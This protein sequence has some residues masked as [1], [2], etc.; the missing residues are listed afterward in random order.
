LWILFSSHQYFG[1][2]AISILSGVLLFF[3]GCISWSDVEKRIPWGIV[4]LYGGAITLGIGMH[5]TGAGTW[6]ADILFNTVSN[7]LYIVVL[8][9]IVFTVLLTGIMS[10]VGAVAILLPIGI[11]VAD[12]IG[13]SPLL[14]SMIIALCGGLAFMLVISTPGNAITYSSG[15]FSTRDL[16]KV[17]FIANIICIIIVFCVAIFY[18]IEVLHLD[19][20]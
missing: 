5:S 2:A 14:S 17:G 12:K 6:L 19:M 10:N 11:A 20:L 7:N 18:W 16:F 8:I 4:L 3:T 15:Y 13:F 1:L 9:M